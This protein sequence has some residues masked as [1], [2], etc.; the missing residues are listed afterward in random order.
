MYY[1]LPLRRKTYVE[2]MMKET[3]QWY[4]GKHDEKRR[5]PRG[6]PQTRM[7][8]SVKKGGTLEGGRRTVSWN[9]W[10]EDA[11]SRAAANL[12]FWRLGKHERNSQ[13]GKKD[14]RNLYARWQFSNS[15]AVFPFSMAVILF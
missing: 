8:E 14:G 11:P 2:R 13:D 7:L 1:F 10:K 3:F 9:A 4:R 12:F 15:M 5:H 6:R